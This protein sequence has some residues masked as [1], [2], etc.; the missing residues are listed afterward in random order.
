MLGVNASLSASQALSAMVG[1][2][3]LFGDAPFLRAP[4]GE[5]GGSETGPR[6][7]GE[8]SDNSDL[9]E[10][11]E[12]LGYEPPSFSPSTPRRVSM[13]KDREVI[14]AAIARRIKMFLRSHDLSRYGLPGIVRFG[15]D[16]FGSLQILA[17]HPKNKQTHAWLRRNGITPETSG[18]ALV[19]K[20]KSD[21]EM[22]WEL[23]GDGR[24]ARTHLSKEAKLIGQVDFESGRIALYT[25]ADGYR[26]ERMNPLRAMFQK[27]M[28]GSAD[29][30]HPELL[31]GRMN[32]PYSALNQRDY[33]L[34]EE[35]SLSYFKNFKNGEQTILFG[36]G[37]GTGQL[38][39][40]METSLV[41]AKRIPY[42][43]F[44]LRYPSAR[45][46]PEAPA[47]SVEH[48]IWPMRAP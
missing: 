30:L 44:I 41:N 47:F 39:L 11:K 26:D 33:Q 28:G 24:L 16:F 43:T 18:N 4:T 5:D 37:S 32:V 40:Q 2:T 15:P 14:H 3:P 17:T 9:P 38:P 25:G 29:F 27:P 22:K 21:I 12:V 23:S 10:T 13:V 1:V 34:L 36:Q 6:P 31:V 42:E 8:S 20:L 48:F 19:G 46:E 35:S 7:K 45:T